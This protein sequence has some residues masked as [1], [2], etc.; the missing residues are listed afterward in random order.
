MSAWDGGPAVNVNLGV[1]GLG[2]ELAE[3]FS[4]A[5]RIGVQAVGALMPKLT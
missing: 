3:A 5:M 2:P 4:W 1:M